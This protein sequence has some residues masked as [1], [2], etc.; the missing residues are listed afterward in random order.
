VSTGTAA[1]DGPVEVERLVNACGLIA[2]VGRQHPV[3]IQFAGRRVTVRD[4]SLSGPGIA[5]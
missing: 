5:W 2:F 1:T 4:L 3:R